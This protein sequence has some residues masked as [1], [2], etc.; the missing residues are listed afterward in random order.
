MSLVI[1]SIVIYLLIL[2]CEV[3]EDALLILLILAHDMLFAIGIV[4]LYLIPLLKWDTMH[5]GFNIQFY[6]AFAS[7]RH[8]RRISSTWIIVCLFVNFLKF[9]DPCR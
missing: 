6:R 9:L 8:S 5:P 3:F 4:C 1:T 7:I 2:L